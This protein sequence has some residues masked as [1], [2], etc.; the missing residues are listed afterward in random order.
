MKKFV[1]L[2]NDKT[3]P[4]MNRKMMTLIFFELYKVSGD[5]TGI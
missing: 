3:W 1:A 2:L 4:R 5:N